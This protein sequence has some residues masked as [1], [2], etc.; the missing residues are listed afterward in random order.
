MNL[1]PRTQQAIFDIETLVWEIS[2]GYFIPKKFRGSPF[3][4]ELRAEYVAYLGTEVDRLKGNVA[5]T[6]FP[7][8]KVTH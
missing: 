7:K 2:Q 4:M 5:T 3:T 6:G 1:N 8:P